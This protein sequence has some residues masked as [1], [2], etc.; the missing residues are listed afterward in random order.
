MYNVLNFLPEMSHI[1]LM[2]FSS[3][4]SYSNLESFVGNLAQKHTH[5]HGHLQ[6]IMALWLALQT[7]FI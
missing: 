7:K 1:N 4:Q 5:T 6:Y 2:K 3:R